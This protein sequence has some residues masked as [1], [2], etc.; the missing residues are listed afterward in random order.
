[1]YAWPKFHGSGP[2]SFWENDLN[3]NTQQKFTKSCFIFVQSFMKISQRVSEL[4]SWHNF[5]Y[6][7]FRIGTVPQKIWVE[8]W[9]LFSTHFLNMLYICTK[10]HE[11]IS[12]GFRVMKRLDFQYSEFSKG[13]NSVKNVERSMI[14]ALCI[15][16][17]HVLYLYN[18]SWKYLK[19]FQSYWADMISN[20]QIF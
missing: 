19:G 1:M 18:V 11:N 5:L 17:N 13:H 8:V 15:S 6:Q 10:C 9:S 3:A 14:F 7:N 20:I 16:S 4:L 12:Q 2:Y